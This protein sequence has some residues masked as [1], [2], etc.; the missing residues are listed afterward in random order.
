MVCLLVRA[1]L[2]RR[3]AA[4]SPLSYEGAAGALPRSALRGLDVHHTV[5]LSLAEAARGTVKDVRT[6][7][8]E[9]CI[10]CG[11]TGAGPGGGHGPVPR[12]MAQDARDPVPTHV[13][14]WG[15]RFDRGY[16]LAQGV[17]AVVAVRDYLTLR[18]CGFLPAC[19]VTG[20]CGVSRVKVNQGHAEGRAVNSCCTSSS[21]MTLICIVQLQR[22]PTS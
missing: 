16:Y 18:E 4:R 14:M 5:H 8:H 21:T 11:G 2:M 6:P 3:L 1:G 7:R 9:V 12:A 17:E 19:P 13:Y 10:L 15:Q 20:M 22:V